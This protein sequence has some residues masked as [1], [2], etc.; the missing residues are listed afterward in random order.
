MIL[1]HDK[2]LLVTKTGWS[3]DANGHIWCFEGGAY[4]SCNL[5][6]AESKNG[7]KFKCVVYL[8]DRAGRVTR[9]AG[10]GQF[11]GNFS[12]IWIVVGGKSLQLTEV[13]RSKVNL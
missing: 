5:E 9:H 11:I 12:P 7:L 13:L 8:Q 4:A 2:Q 6:Y 10:R 1:P 3:T